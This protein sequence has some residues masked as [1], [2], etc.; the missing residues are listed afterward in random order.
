MSQLNIAIAA[1]GFLILVTGLINL[2]LQKSP[3]T[4]PMIAMATG[5]F[6]SPFLLNV[7]DFDSWGDA[8]SIME[9]ACRFTLAMALMA[10][11]LR[12]PP[13]Y[14]FKSKK[15]QIPLILL[16]MTLMSLFSGLIIYYLFDLPFLV[17]MTIGAVVAPTDPVVAATLVSGPVAEKTCPAASGMPF[18]V[19]PEQTTASGSLL[20]CSRFCSSRNL[21]LHFPNGF[22]G[23][24]CGKM[25]E[26]F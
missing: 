16:G 6:L 14:P 19:N 3:I 8:H 21:K 2:R 26:E 5:I 25:Q 22:F 4:E 12:L 9:Q 1:T 11:A 15:T 18:R 7:L 10:T 24:F 17:S 23:L 13:G 20:S